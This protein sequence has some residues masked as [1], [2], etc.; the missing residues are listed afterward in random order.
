V[1]DIDILSD[2][3]KIVVIGWL[4]VDYI[5]LEE[6]ILVSLAYFKKVIYDD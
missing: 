6:V 1:N 3:R 2:N 5:E 4:P